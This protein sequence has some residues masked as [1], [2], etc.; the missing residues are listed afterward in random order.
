MAYF[1]KVYNEVKDDVVFLM[2]DVVDGVQETEEKGKK[3]IADNGF[4]F[5]VLYDLD[6]DAAKTYGIRAF[7]TTI[8]VNKDGTVLGGQ[9]GALPEE[10]LRAVVE[11]IK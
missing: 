3:Y 1:D 10:V 4:T 11:Q 5:P 7:P 2:I 8:V 9:E 6:M